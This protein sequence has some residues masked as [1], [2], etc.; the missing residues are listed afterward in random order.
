MYLDYD[1]IRD[2]YASDRA[3]S[4]AREAGMLARAIEAGEIAS[5]ALRIVWVICDRCHGDGGHSHRFGSYSA[6]EFD[7]FDDEFQ[8]GYLSGRFDERCE[9]CAGSGKVRVIDE[10]SLTDE[11]AKYLADAREDAYETASM[12]YAERM[13]GA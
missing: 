12:H 13:M 10:E 1:S 8:D 11:A 2:G 4:Y 7:E 3:C 9:V 5:F 6:D